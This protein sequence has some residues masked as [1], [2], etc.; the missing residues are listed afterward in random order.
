[1][2][3][4]QVKRKLAAILSAKVRGGQP[5]D[6]RGRGVTLRTLNDYKG[7]IRNLAGEHRGR[8]VASPGDNVLA[9]FA[10]VVN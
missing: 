8:V 7:I 6:G 10:S 2:T 3:S 5:H 9:E 1:M 4:D